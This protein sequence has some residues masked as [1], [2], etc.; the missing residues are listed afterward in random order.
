MTKIVKTS[1]E[2]KTEVISIIDGI[3]KDAK[4]YVSMLGQFKESSKGGVN[5]SQIDKPVKNFLDKIRRDINKDVTNEDAKI[6]FPELCKSM[7]AKTSFDEILTFYYNSKKEKI[8]MTPENRQKRIAAFSE[9]TINAFSD[10]VTI[11]ETAAGRFNLKVSDMLE[12]VKASANFYT[13]NTVAYVAKAKKVAAAAPAKAPEAKKPTFEE[14]VT[15]QGIDFA[16]LKTGTPIYA[17]MKT[18]FD[19]MIAA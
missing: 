3:S 1:E 5:F 15:A 6:T 4:G 13:R 12:I 11:K 14:Y 7:S 10:V 8:A 16:N 19:A 2:F 18:Q 9:R 17:M